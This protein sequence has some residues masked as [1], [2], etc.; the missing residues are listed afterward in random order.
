MTHETA[1]FATLKGQYAV[2][3]QPVTDASDS[4]TLRNWGG[5]SDRSDGRSCFYPIYVKG[6]S[7]VGFG[8]VL[9]ENEHPSGPN[10][11][12]DDGTI[13]V[14]PID[15]N[16]NEKKWRYARQTVDG[17][18][19]LLTPKIITR[20]VRKGIID[21]EK[22]NRSRPFRSV[23]TDPRHDAST[24]GTRMVRTFAGAPFPYPKSL[25]ATYDALYAAVAHKPDAVIL[26]FFA[27]SGTTAHATFLL[28]TLDGGSRQS[29]VVTNN[30]VGAEQAA[31][32]RK[33]G[34]KPGADEYEIHGIFQSVTWPRTQAAIGGSTPLGELSSTQYL[35][36][37]ERSWSDGFEEN[38]QSFELT[39]Q[40][41]GLVELD[42]AFAAI[43]PLLWLRAGGQGPVIAERTDMQGHPVPYRCTDHY[44]VL[45][46]T[47]H[48]RRFIEQLPDEAG[49]AFI[50]TDS[51]TTFSA[52]A[53]DLPA[54]VE[55]VRLYE[56]Y[57][58]TFEIN[59][60]G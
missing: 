40:D 12:M 1:V 21:I 46:D 58:S 15:A 32:L 17:I 22:A 48:W 8:E 30:E 60:G 33:D 42:L 56:N 9:P 4:N 20:G 25:H 13:A 14:W 3:H 37:D 18:R 27:G 23:W 26:D 39:Y 41:A 51:S 52:V 29:I 55:A 5:E 10:E 44:G 49:V 57:L 47:D 50:V 43:A 6:S 54:G 35:G 59:R 31:S 38:V 11:I 53:K 28:N 36:G 7:I 24:H 34:V 19:H 2:S 16:L 45:F